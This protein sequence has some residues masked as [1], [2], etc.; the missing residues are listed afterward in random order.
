MVVLTKRRVRARHHG[1]IQ[2]SKV[3]VGRRTVADPVLWSETPQWPG[4]R[5][6]DENPRSASHF[7]ASS[8]GGI[9]HFIMRQTYFAAAQRMVISIFRLLDV[10]F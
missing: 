1:F 5:D 3:G 7:G 6:G 4:P 8:R 9:D 10:S 2:Q